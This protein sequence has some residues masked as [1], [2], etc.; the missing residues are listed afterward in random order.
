MSAQEQINKAIAAHG[1]WK[2]RLK[3][4]VEKG[5]SEFQPAVVKADHNCDFGKWLHGTDVPAG[6]KA[7]PEFQEVIQL[8]AAFH[9]AAGHVLELALSGQRAEAEK[10]MGQG[11]EF[12]KLSADMIRKL[13]AF[14]NSLNEAA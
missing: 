8:H 13:M 6:L 3:A 5:S 2:T 7:K 14:K 1:Q 9:K 4:A 12:S 10:S 11:S